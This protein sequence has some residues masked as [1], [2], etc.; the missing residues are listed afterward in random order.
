MGN[1]WTCL[2]APSSFIILSI[3]LKTPIKVV[4]GIWQVLRNGGRKRLS[5]QSKQPLKGKTLQRNRETASGSGDLSMKHGPEV[6]GQSPACWQTC[7]RNQPPLS[8]E[9]GR[10]SQGAVRD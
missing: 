10:G 6:Q 4:E 2:D 7:D 3:Y 9:H 8:A 5:R 1:C